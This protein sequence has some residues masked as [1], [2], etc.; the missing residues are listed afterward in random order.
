MHETMKL[1]DHLCMQLS[2]VM[3]TAMILRLLVAIVTWHIVYIFTI[4]QRNTGQ[5]YTKNNA[6]S[7]QLRKMHS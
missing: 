3:F 2:L 7:N 6:E 4:T 1:V 5:A